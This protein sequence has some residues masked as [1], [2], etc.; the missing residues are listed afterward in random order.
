M[1]ILQNLVFVCADCNLKKGAMTL[2]EFIK[3]FRLD[4]KTVYARLE[5][6]GKRI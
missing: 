2:R 5:L 1:S 6:R 3:T 4:E